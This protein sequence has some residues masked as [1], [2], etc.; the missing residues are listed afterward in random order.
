MDKVQ[1]PSYTK[2]L[3]IYSDSAVNFI[4]ASKELK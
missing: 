3:N 1:K 4:R 2:C